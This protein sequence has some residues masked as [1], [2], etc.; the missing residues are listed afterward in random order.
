MNQTTFRY[1]IYHEEEDVID[2]IRTKDFVSTAESIVSI[3]CKS[4]ECKNPIAE[5]KT[6]V[7]I[8]LVDSHKEDKLYLFLMDKFEDIWFDF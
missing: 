3:E 7:K 8:T 1:S 5:K 6:K 4:P 2:T